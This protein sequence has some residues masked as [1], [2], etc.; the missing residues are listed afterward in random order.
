[1]RADVIISLHKADTQRGKVTCPRSHSKCGRVRIGAPVPR[2]LSGCILPSHCPSDCLCL[3]P[4]LLNRLPRTWFSPENTAYGPGLCTKSQNIRALGRSEGESPGKTV[5]GPSYFCPGI[6][7]C[8]APVI[9]LNPTKVSKIFHLLI[10]GHNSRAQ[11]REPRLW[12]QGG[13]LANPGSTTHWLCN[14]S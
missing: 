8:L 12:D 1:M 13:A 9:P 4:P 2:I 5:R 14:P 6:A 10:C 3:Q 11:R 7:G